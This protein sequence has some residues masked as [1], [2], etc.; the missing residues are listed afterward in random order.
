MGERFSSYLTETKFKM[1]ATAAILDV[2]RQASSKI[3]FLSKTATTK[4]ISGQTPERFSS[5]LTETIFKMAAVVSCL[6]CPVAA[7][8]ERNLPL[9]DSNHQKKFQVKWVNGSPVI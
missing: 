2:Q 4:K 1:A 5:Y 7:I 9:I 3:T 8:I 6:G